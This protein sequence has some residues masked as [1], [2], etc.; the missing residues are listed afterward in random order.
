MSGY[1]RSPDEFFKLQAVYDQELVV[2]LRK[3]AT[4]GPQVRNNLVNEIPS[5]LLGQPTESTVE[6][7]GNKVTTLLDTGST[8]STLAYSYFKD[9]LSSTL[10][11]PELHTLLDIECAGGTQL[12][13]LGFMEARITT[14]KLTELIRSLLY[15][16]VNITGIYLYYLE[17]IYLKL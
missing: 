7:E 6:L 5:G 3:N 8:V 1:F 12:P 11:L 15:H 14:K 2:G 9:H 13:Y 17:R 4:H 10:K 16:L